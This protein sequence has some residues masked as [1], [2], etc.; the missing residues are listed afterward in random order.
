MDL[1]EPG[2]CPVIERPCREHFTAIGDVVHRL[3]DRPIESAA[4]EQVPHITADCGHDALPPVCLTSAEKVP[5]EM[6]LP[7][8]PWIVVPRDA[9]STGD[10]GAPDCCVTELTLPARDGFGTYIQAGWT[11]SLPVTSAITGWNRSGGKSGVY[12]ARTTS[13]NTRCDTMAASSVMSGLLLSSSLLICWESRSRNVSLVGVP[14]LSL[15]PPESGTGPMWRATLS[16]RRRLRSWLRKSRS[17][18]SSTL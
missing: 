13:S 15:Q 6:E 1:A 5:P 8:L 17:C 10:F 14:M 2:H 16:R 9:S 7:T 11:N 4:S 3:L 12:P 18:S